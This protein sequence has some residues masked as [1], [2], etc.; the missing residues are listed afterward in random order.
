MTIY[1][2]EVVKFILSDGKSRG[3]HIDP[4][5]LQKMQRGMLLKGTEG[6]HRDEESFQKPFFP[7]L[8]FQKNFVTRQMPDGKSDHRKSYRWAREF[9]LT[10]VKWNMV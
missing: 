5:L 8:L 10:Y 2:S 1:S 7:R 9:H 3:F 4:S 6:E